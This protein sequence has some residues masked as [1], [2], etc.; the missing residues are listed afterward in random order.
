MVM[1]DVIAVH[2]QREVQLALDVAAGLD[3][4]PADPAASGAGLLGDQHVADHRL[5][6]PP[7]PRPRTSPAAR[8]PCRVRIVLEVP[9]AT[10]ARMDLRLHDIDGT[11]AASR[12]P[13][14]PL[15]GVQATKPCRTATP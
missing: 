5:R 15:Q 4:H 3:V 1:R 9:G 7:V 2:Q 6:R 11:G 14:P 10:A 13:A 8:R 12:P